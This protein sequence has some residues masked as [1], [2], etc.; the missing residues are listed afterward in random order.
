MCKQAKQLFKDGKLQEAL[1]LYNQCIQLEPSNYVLYPKRAAVFR[2]LA[3]YESALADGKKCYTLNK[4]YVKGPISLAQTH[5]AMKNE[6][7]AI[8]TMNVSILQEENFSRKL[9]L[10]K[11]YSVLLH[12]GSKVDAKNF[13]EQVEQASNQKQCTS[14]VLV[15]M[16]KH[17]LKI[18]KMSVEAGILKE[19]PTAQYE[20]LVD[21]VM[22][23]NEQVNS[24]T[25][26]EESF[27]YPETRSFI[28]NLL[29]DHSKLKEFVAGMEQFI[30]IGSKATKFTAWNMLK[31]SFPTQFPNEYAKAKS[32]IEPVRNLCMEYCTRCFATVGKLFTALGL[33]LMVLND[34]INNEIVAMMDNKI[35]QIMRGGIAPQSNN[36]KNNKKQSQPQPQQQKPKDKINNPATNAKYCKVCKMDAH[37]KC[38]QCKL[39]DY[40]C[41]EHQQQDWKE[42]KQYCKAGMGV[43]KQPEQ[44]LYVFRNGE[45]ETRKQ[46]GVYLKQQ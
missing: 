28:R 38:G 21:R 37:F 15:E 7:A 25:P 42:H 22:N 14:Q 9:E 45:I 4:A 44:N 35:N 8:Y 11:Y 43:V 30:N 6:Q 20:D 27:L 46:G 18:T 41:K 29:T 24:V 13:D 16:W 10:S 5:V 17:V 2:A 32:F 34:N 40:C 36:K 33:Q 1:A 26:C 12:G 31:C 23:T 39:V 19:L 3:Q